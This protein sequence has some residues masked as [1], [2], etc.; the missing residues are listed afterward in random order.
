MNKQSQQNAKS[1]YKMV[2]ELP[3][4]LDDDDLRSVQLS[5][6]HGSATLD[7]QVQKYE[8]IEGDKQHYY[9]YSNGERIIKETSPY[10]IHDI[11]FATGVIKK[12]VKNNLESYT[13]VLLKDSSP[14]IRS[15]FKTALQSQEKPLLKKALRFWVASR[16]IE[17]PWSI[18]GD[19]TLGME[20]DKLVDSPYYNKVPVTPIMDFQID[21]LVIHEQLQVQLKEILKVLTE[22]MLPPK[23]EHWFDIQLCLFILL[24]SVELTMA[25]DAEFATRYSL[26]VRFDTNLTRIKY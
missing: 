8:P 7:L 1:V 17:K 6:G 14:I 15:T 2:T 22:K 11:E 19:E 9:W 16:F 23:K 18:I 20:S 12:F 24:H 4:W 13:K 10:A 3:E 25:H 5:Q 21:N 26:E